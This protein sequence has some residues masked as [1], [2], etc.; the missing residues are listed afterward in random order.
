MAMIVGSTRW[1]AVGAALTVSAMSGVLAAAEY[2]NRPIRL[3]VPFATGSAT[4]TSARIF[5][6]ELT[7]GLGQQVIADNRAGAGGAIGMQML[8][9]ATADGYTLAY[10][11][12]GPLAINRSVTPDLPYDVERDFQPV[13]QAVSAPMMLAVTPKLPV[14][15]VRELI[16]LAKSKPGG[17][18]MGSAGTGTIGHLSGEYFKMMSGTDMV[19]VPYKGGGQAA[20]DLI[21]GNIQLMF[22]P[23]TGITPHVRSGKVRGLAVTSL[24]R[25]AAFPDIPTVAESGLPGFEVTT[26]G[27]VVA[28]RGIPKTVLE[29]LNTEMRKAVQSTR[30]IELYAAMGSDPLAGSPQEFAVLIR[31]ETEKWARVVA[32]ALPK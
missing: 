18:S 16:A 7:K 19:H 13:S 14:K 29:R 11:G 1:L 28:P 2:P 10:A 4:D 6:A 22:D 12:A 24:K 27:G 5:A 3:I 26:W 8:A 15:N 20:I 21:A 9:K 31:S 25:A 23:M 32:R 30:V 17:L